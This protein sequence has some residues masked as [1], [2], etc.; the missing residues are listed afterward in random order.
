MAIYGLKTLDDH[1]KMMLDST[2]YVARLRW[3]KVVSANADG[4]EVVPGIT[5]RKPFPAG[6]PLAD[7]IAHDVV[8][9]GDTVTWTHRHWN[10]EDSVNTLIYVFL[11]N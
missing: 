8:I 6:V 7:G 5:G 3:T 10:N 4:S 11:L 1:S 2:H 9:N